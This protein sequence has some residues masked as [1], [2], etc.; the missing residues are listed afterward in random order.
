MSEPTELNERSS[1]EMSTAALA[2]VETVSTAAAENFDAETI[3]TEAA[4]NIDAEEKSVADMTDD[5][6]TLWMAVL[7]AAL[8]AAGEPLS[9]TKF[10]NLFEGEIEVPTRG[11]LKL[12]LDDLLAM[13]SIT[14][15]R[16]VETA[17]GFQYQVCPD[18]MP[19]VK[20]LWTEK[21]PKYSRAIMETLSL[22]AY[23]GPITRGEIED[24]RGVAVSTHIIKTLEE[25]EWVKVV[26]HKDVPGKPALFSTTKQFLD[27]F[28]LKRLNDLPSLP[29]IKSLDEKA[30]NLIGIQIELPLEASA[31]STI[32]AAESL[33]VSESAEGVE[34][35]ENIE[36]VESADP[37]EIDEYVE[38][39]E[40]IENTESIEASDIIEPAEMD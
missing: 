5:Q 7:Q 16:L 13:Q 10:M 2:E 17:S 27:Y 26:G 12:L 34:I 11:M 18:Y 40:T 29:E 39:A 21:P 31:A 20:K 28:N 14:A 35:D 32:E 19:W 3:A 33:E 22:I 30:K 25:R 1:E 15:L 23:Q 4:P 38:G 36:P 37:V 24:I 8:L 9:L 6:R